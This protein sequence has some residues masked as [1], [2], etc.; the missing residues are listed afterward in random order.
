[1]LVRRQLG[2]IFSDVILT[3]LVFLSLLRTYRALWLKLGL[4]T[5]REMWKN[6]KT[7]VFSLFDLASSKFAFFGQMDYE[8]RVNCNSFLPWLL[9]FDSF[10]MVTFIVQFLCYALS[11][12]MV[13]TYMI[14]YAWDQRSLGFTIW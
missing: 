4:L 6:E 5:P 8:I 1:M 12:S 14:N 9:S 2:F 3:D 7:S 10:L 11:R 13:R